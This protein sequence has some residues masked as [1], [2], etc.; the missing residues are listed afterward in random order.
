MDY[1]PAELFMQ[2]LTYA[3][4]KEIPCSWIY[5]E[6]DEI[7]LLKDQ[8]MMVEEAKSKFGVDIET[9]TLPSSHSPFLSMPEKL[10]EIVEIIGKRD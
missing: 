10:V 2:P 8:K 4:W 6:K 3:S 7:V 1:Q 5:T 9:F